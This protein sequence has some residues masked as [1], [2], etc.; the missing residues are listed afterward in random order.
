MQSFA[1][2]KGSPKKIPEIVGI[3][4]DDVVTSNVIFIGPLDSESILNKLLNAV[5]MPNNNPKR[6]VK[7]ET[8]FFKSNIPNSKTH[9]EYTVILKKTICFDVLS[10]FL[11][12]LLK[13]QF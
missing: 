1:R 8:E 4:I 3:I 12:Q 13:R 10:F 5:T 6:T 7:T 9:T 11:Q 2:L